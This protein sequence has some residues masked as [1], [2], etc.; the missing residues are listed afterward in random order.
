[1]KIKNLIHITYKTLIMKKNYLFIILSVIT[2]THN[3]SYAYDCQK[4]EWDNPINVTI[5]NSDGSIH[6]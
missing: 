2:F 1:M 4:V 6:N 3:I 5:D